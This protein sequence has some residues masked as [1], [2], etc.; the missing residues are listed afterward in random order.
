VETD[1]LV[2]LFILGGEYGTHQLSRPWREVMEA[3]LD[4]GL[5]MVL[6]RRI[7][8]NVEDHCRLC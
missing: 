5:L 3:G 1:R 8:T 7:V 6:L 4:L 2:S